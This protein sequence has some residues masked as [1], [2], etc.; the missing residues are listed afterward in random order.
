MMLEGAMLEGVSRG[1]R[2][3]ELL[4]EAGAWVGR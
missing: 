1:E 4:V 3:R 2:G